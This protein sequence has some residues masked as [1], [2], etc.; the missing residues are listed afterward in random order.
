M[1]AVN[2][3][4]EKKYYFLLWIVKLWNY[5]KRQ[6]E[7][8]HEEDF[9]QGFLTHEKQLDAKGS[10]VA[11]LDIYEHLEGEAFSSSFRFSKERFQKN[12]SSYQSVNVTGGQEFLS[13]LFTP[14][15]L[16][17]GM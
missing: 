12:S 2:I 3:F 16:V 11:K 4:K 9:Y 17:P 14:L 1:K 10:Y 5:H 15:S 8:K 7:N 6:V 13:V